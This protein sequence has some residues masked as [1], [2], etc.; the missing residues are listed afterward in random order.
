MLFTYK[1]EKICK[2]SRARFGLY[3]R[4]ERQVKMAQAT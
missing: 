2:A 4:T 1:W 3:I